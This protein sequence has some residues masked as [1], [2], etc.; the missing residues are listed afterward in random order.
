MRERDAG[1]ASE[2]NTLFERA[3]TLRRCALYVQRT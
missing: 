2:F 1:A 3:P